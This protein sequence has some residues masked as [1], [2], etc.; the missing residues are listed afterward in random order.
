MTRSEFRSL[1]IGD[2]VSILPDTA[3]FVTNHYARIVDGKPIYFIVLNDPLHSIIPDS[4][5]HLV[6]TVGH[7]QSY[8]DFD[9]KDFPVHENEANP[10]SSSF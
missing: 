10:C 1:S 7:R 6:S 8:W 5:A 2:A 4:L 3:N 9:P